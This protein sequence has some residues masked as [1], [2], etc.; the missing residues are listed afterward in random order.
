MRLS[1]AITDSN[2]DGFASDLLVIRGT[3][4][5]DIVV[6]VIDKANTDEKEREAGRLSV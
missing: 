4:P 3:E 2:R 1:F 6:H 5:I